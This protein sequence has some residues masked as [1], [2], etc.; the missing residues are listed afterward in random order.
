[1]EKIILKMILFTNSMIYTLQGFTYW[2]IKLV[3]NDMDW[4]LLVWPILIGWLTQPEKP[5]EYTWP[6]ITETSEEPPSVGKL[7]FSILNENN[8]SNLKMITKY[9][10]Y[11]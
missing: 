10:Y 6:D 2:P 9:Y 5:V 11:I 3:S 4:T 7:I 8:V 1:M